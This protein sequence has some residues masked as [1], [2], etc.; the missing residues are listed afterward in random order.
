[1]GPRIIDFFS[2][3]FSFQDQQCK[4]N[5][6][7]IGATVAGFVDIPSGNERALQKASATVGPIS[8]VIDASH[9]SFQFYKSGVYDE[10]ECSTT[11]L[12]HDVLVVGYG[13]SRG[14]IKYWL[15]KN[16]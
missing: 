16:R 9:F 2:T 3:F 10:P 12:D 7:N 5:K 8:V 15:V 6:S 13:K 11:Q 14:G 1:M 4:F